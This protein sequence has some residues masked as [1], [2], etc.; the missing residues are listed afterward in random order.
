MLPDQG[1][2]NAPETTDA[3]LA[4][5]MPQRTPRLKHT[6][7][8]IATGGRATRQP[9]GLNSGLRSSVWPANKPAGAP[10]HVATRLPNSLSGSRRR[11]C[12]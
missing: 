7:S 6:A 11:A 10:H 2:S 1:A 8:A 9:T 5:H 3:G 4:P 12:R